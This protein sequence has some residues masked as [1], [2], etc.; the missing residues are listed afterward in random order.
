MKSSKS[1]FI[2]IYA[3]SGLS[4]IL[5]AS[6]ACQILGQSTVRS[7]VKMFLRY[8]GSL[9]SESYTSK[10]TIDDTKDIPFRKFGHALD[11]K[12]SE[13][14]TYWV[15]FLTS[16]LSYD[17]G[18]EGDLDE[19]IIPDW[20]TAGWHRLMNLPPKS[21]YMTLSTQQLQN[22]QKL[23]PLI[24]QPILGLDKAAFIQSGV[25]FPSS[26]APTVDKNSHL[27]L[28][29]C[30]FYA[31]AT[32]SPSSILSR[33]AK[34]SNI[35]PRSGYTADQL[36]GHLRTEYIRYIVD[37]SSD[38]QYSSIKN[39]KTLI[40]LPDLLIHFATCQ[41]YYNLFIDQ[42]PE[43]ALFGIKPAID[44]DDSTLNSK[45]GNRITREGES[46]II[47]ISEIT[48]RVYDAFQKKKSIDR[49]TLNRFISDIYGENSHTRE[50]FKSVL[51]KMF[52]AKHSE[53]PKIYT[54]L[55][56]LK[57]S[58]YVRAIA[59]T[60]RIVDHGDSNI[61]L[62]EHVL[63][64]WFVKLGISM[65]PKFMA[66]MQKFFVV[67]SSFAGIGALLKCKHESLL[68]ISGDADMKKIY[69]KF[70]L[71]DR[72]IT[73]RSGSNQ[74]KGG[75]LMDVFQVKRRFQ[76]TVENGLKLK[77]PLSVEEINTA[78]VDD[79]DSDSS[80][81]EEGHNLPIQD[82]DANRNSSENTQNHEVP[83]NAIDEVNFVNMLSQGENDDGHG[84]FL[85][86]KLAQLL[87]HA[88]RTRLV[89]VTEDS[90]LKF[91]VDSYLGLKKNATEERKKC[92]RNDE[93]NYWDLFDVIA[94]SCSAVRGGLVHST[95]TDRLLLEYIFL[96]FLQLPDTT[97]TTFEITKPRLIKRDECLT[98]NQLGHMILLLL[99]HA[100][101]RLR[102]DS[103]DGS[104]FEDFFKGSE[105]LE[106]ILVDSS[107]ASILG[108]H[109]KVKNWDA[110]TSR[111]EVASGS[112][113]P[114]FA[115]VENIFLSI[116]GQNLTNIKSSL[117][118]F[119]NFLFWSK[120][121]SN[122]LGLDASQIKIGPLLLDLRLV[123]SVAFG[124]KP[125]VPSM[126]MIL[127]EELQRRYRTKISSC[128]SAKRGRINTK[129]FIINSSWW[130]EW[131]NY[132]KS[133]ATGVG[134]AKIN[135]A[136]LMLSNGSLA[137]KSGLRF[138]YDFELV[139]PLVWSALH[140]WYDGGP[141]ISRSVVPFSKDQNAPKYEIELYPLY[142][143]VLLLDSYGDVR[144]FQ[145]YVS[146]SKHLPLRVL[147]HELCSRLNMDPCNGR[148]RMCVSTAEMK[149]FNV[150]S[151]LD[152]DFSL[153]DQLKFDH[154]IDSSTQHPQKTVDIVLELKTSQ[155]I[156]PSEYNESVHK[157]RKEVN[158]ESSDRGDGIFALHNM[159]NTC[160]M[161][162]SI[163]I[164]SH[165]PLLKDYFISKAYLNDINK[166]NPLGYQGRLAQVCAVLISSLWNASSRNKSGTR[167]N[168]SLHRS[169]S[170]LDAPVL[171]PQTFKNTIG[172]LNSD[173][174]GNEQH[175][176]QELLTFLLG[177]LS[178][179]LN[180]IGD[181][182]YTEDPDSD[183][184]PDE[185]LADIW[186]SNHLKR[187]LS[188]IV[189][190]F[191]G[192]YKSVLSCKSCKYESARFEPFCFLQLPLPN[193]QVTVHIVY[194]PLHK[195]SSAEKFAL[196][197]K[198]DAKLSEILITLARV[199]YEDVSMSE[200]FDIN[201]T[202]CTSTQED[203]CVKHAQNMT[204][205]RIENGYVAN[206]PSVSF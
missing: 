45:R 180:R 22:P 95:D 178:E 57:D 145:Q 127:I 147:L 6:E 62:L 67:S 203:W 83:R 10:Q 163:Q 2:P 98:W 84:G 126:E 35:V 101:F 205:A 8:I 202:Q 76:S 50:H 137:M 82:E 130:S 112:M 161:N 81:E 87:F 149:P 69:T 17:F 170:P 201:N 118:S 1:D 68:K 175:D 29:E 3:I 78:T 63:L 53:E 151:I 18:N 66:T 136:E 59:K 37:H 195:G 73:S 55:R 198:Y 109:P 40:V 182:P 115:I 21:A 16:S 88:G 157:G 122:A 41:K 74:D 104:D 34:A 7:I 124:V 86:P 65:R 52:Q 97:A 106:D 111:E 15:N 150:N 190:L 156:W 164:I 38:S 167:S 20:C 160:F 85:T 61:C 9:T 183:G 80:I 90:I 184:R 19:N 100:A 155:G 189:A 30:I 107:A 116:P 91:Q 93:R 117:L 146:V 125:S 48:F 168:M 13:E 25:I 186:W 179:D 31:L 94:F 173:F 71:V 204:L 11:E 185:E 89:H 5:T 26:V 153:Q 159:G 176:A 141:P 140:A 134:P 148:L 193:D 79:S 4:H 28:M 49:D 96:M 138:R 197:T 56:D 64:D 154:Q 75:S 108:I 110:E 23:N 192:Q 181:K 129:W 14:E 120:K 132:S 33:V 70:G 133:Y 191:N 103:P 42:S 51:D 36:E 169:G 196:K 188:I 105:F 72:S 114:L 99:D 158:C 58:Q 162:S 172:K 119:D 92:L 199:L 24:P 60:V 27:A 77:S 177:G 113:V 54:D 121:C 139:P 32:P 166:T 102:T 39:N 174:Q 144:P 135:N 187:E 206:I 143:T 44:R 152:L 47:A 12:E 128:D 46:A 131:E 194:F 43:K 123:G 200:Y 165:T 171:T 142:V